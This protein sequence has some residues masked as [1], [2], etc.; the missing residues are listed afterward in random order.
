MKS[1]QKI[2]LNDLC[3][4]IVDSEHKTA[5]IQE[6]GIPYVRT[7]NIKNGRLNLKDSKR[8]SEE[9]YK[10]WSERLEPKPHDLILSREAPVGEVGMILPGQRVCLGQRTVLVRTDEKKIYSKYLLYLLQTRQFQHKMHSHADGTHVA[11]LNMKEIRNLELGDLPN[12]EDQKR[13]G[14]FLFNLDLLLELKIK[15]N[16]IFE[17]I[18][19]AIFKSWFIDFDSQ[20]KFVD[21]ELGKIPKGWIVA[22]IDDVADFVNGLPLQ[23]YRPI[24]ENFLP[25][26][27]IKEMKNGISARTEKASP[28]IEKKFVVNDGDIL[29]SWSGT[30]EL[31]IWCYGKGALNQHIFKVTSERFPKWFYYQWIKFHLNEFRKIA[32]GKVTTMGH[33][34]RHHLSEALVVIPP[35]RILDEFNKILDPLF[36][37]II[38]N[39]IKTLTLQKIRVSLLPKLM[40]GQIQV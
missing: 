6:F 38:Y 8:V 1:K 3:D 23:K 26:I 40:S 9:T 4:T 31:T 20:T 22:P 18:I 11:H 29:F 28:D 19:Q 16:E 25:V 2:I 24:N 21:S 5:P 32:S 39:K 15:I 17:K 14:N 7:S 36:N 33:I 37:E 30:L 34:Q 10:E 13:I 35:K 12:I 27:K